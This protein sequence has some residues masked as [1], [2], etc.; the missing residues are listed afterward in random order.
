MPGHLFRTP[1]RAAHSTASSIVFDTETVPAAERFDYWRGLY[2]SFA[3][4]DAG[5]AQRDG[6][7]ARSESWRVGPFIVVDA[8]SADLVFRRSEAHCARSENDHIVLR[9]SESASWTS[10]EQDREER[11]APGELFLKR[12]VKPSLT[13]VPSG[14]YTLMFLPVS[15]YAELAEPL[16]RLRAGRQGT[17]GARMLAD[18]LLALPNRLRAMSDDDIGP[19]AQSLIAVVA[20]CLLGRPSPPLSEATE[21]GSPARKRVMRV[22]RENMGSALLDVNQISRLS[23]MSRTTLYRMFGDEGGVATVVRNMRLRAVM[24]DFA[25]PVLVGV[26]IARIAERRGLHN[27]ASFSRAFRRA[28][29]RS[30]TEARAGALFRPAEQ[31]A[32]PVGARVGRPDPLVD[33]SAPSQ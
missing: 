15:A 13:H 4:L 10:A 32:I 9:V 2:E 21:T 8:H 7:S 1:P 23:G 18:V 17:P 5:A 27:A 33:R 12:S 28:F 6:F 26:P 24:E 14:R 3:E 16:S 31:D 20:T 19:L 30:P 29:G 25:N 11:I 22:I